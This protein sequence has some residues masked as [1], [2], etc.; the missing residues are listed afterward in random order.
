MGRHKKIKDF[1]P[2]ESNTLSGDKVNKFNTLL[3]VAIRDSSLEKTVNKG[4]LMKALSEVDSELF[5]EELK[6]LEGTITE[7]LLKDLDVAV[8]HKVRGRE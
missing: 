8:T 2:K 6:L 3:A 4:E 5:K 1:T 7:G